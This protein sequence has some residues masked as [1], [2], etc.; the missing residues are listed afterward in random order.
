MIWRGWLGESRAKRKEE[1]LQEGA[2]SSKP[3]IDTGPEPPHGKE[4]R[5]RECVKEEGKGGKWEPGVWKHFSVGRATGHNSSPSFFPWLLEL[6]ALVI[7][8]HKS[9]KTRSLPGWKPGG[10][11]GGNSGLTWCS[12]VDF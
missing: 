9:F 2:G 4:G 10:G 1:G 3:E 8:V 11:R 6:F 7:A 5:R 12:S